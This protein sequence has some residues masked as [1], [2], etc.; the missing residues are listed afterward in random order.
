MHEK[1]VLA[2]MTSNY[3][4]L[5]KSEKKIAD[6]I[7]AN[8]VNTQ[9]L[10]ITS[11]SDECK[12]AEATIFRF[13]KSLGFVGYNDFKLSLAKSSAGNPLSAS[14]TDYTLFGEIKPEDSIDDMCKKLYS[15]NVAAL[16]QTLELMDTKK[17][18]HAVEILTNSNKVFCL[19]QGASLIIAMEAWGRFV[20]TSPNFFCVEDSH[21]QAMS[22]SLLTE[23]D[24]ILFFSY[25]G[26]TKDML[27]VLRPAKENG[28]KV[29]LVTRFAK[30]PAT[31]FADVILLCGSNEGPLQM[32]AIPS[33]MAQLLL[34]DIIF[35]EYCRQNMEESIKNRE[36]TSNA[37]SLKLL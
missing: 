9:Y 35:N 28:V 27:D 37:I 17:I 33:K 19:G 26:A 29:I 1:D 8:R 11:L 18:K 5:T 21:M 12:V 31:A 6:Y 16:T 14:K 15:S 36:I 30:S 2:A 24:A 23:N 20:T 13:C 22:C 4:S 32:G 3:N 25:S 34:V 7:F 10:S